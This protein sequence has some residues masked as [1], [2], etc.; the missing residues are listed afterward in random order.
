MH[1]WTE[2]R[3]REMWH[4]L[5]YFE[6][7]ANVHD[8]FTGKLQSRRPKVWEATEDLRERAYATA[9]CIRQADQYYQAAGVVGL[10]TRPLLQFYGAQALAKACILAADNVLTL[11]QLKYHGLSSRASNA[12][13][14]RIQDSLQMYSGDPSAWRVELEFAVTHDGV[15]PCLCRVSGDT[16]PPK[17]QVLKFQELVRIMPDMAEVYSRHYA[18]PTHCFNL[19]SGPA[20]GDDGKLEIFFNPPLTCS[21]V[22]RAFSEFDDSYE[23][24]RRHN[25]APGFRS[26]ITLPQVPEFIKV[27]KGTIAGRY[28]V[29]PHPTG[30]YNTPSILYSGLFILSNVVRY[31]PAFWMRA[32]EGMTSG[33]VSIVEAFCNMAERRF[34]NDILELIW[35]EGFTYGTPTYL[36]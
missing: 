30:I 26:R 5:R 20:I 4:Q 23:E 18:E 9:A 36:G 12:A 21:E 24:T 34:P 3:L 6:S 33:A 17:G 32:I 13:D 29:K 35:C 8:L 22:K 27:V 19:Y 14:Q 28:L 16:P 7:P 25:V 10:A 1:I 31:K 2:N 15:F 11:D